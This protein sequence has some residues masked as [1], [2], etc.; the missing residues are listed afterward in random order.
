MADI[1]WYVLYCGCL[2]GPQKKLTIVD[3]CGTALTYYCILH[4]G[5]SGC[6]KEPPLYELVR[7]TG[8]EVK[9]GSESA[10]I[11]EDH[12]AV[13]ELIGSYADHDEGSK[14]TEDG[15]NIEEENET[16]EEEKD[17]GAPY[18]SEED[19]HKGLETVHI[20][21]LSHENSHIGVNDS[22]V[23]HETVGSSLQSGSDW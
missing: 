23:Q 2:W 9:D 22:L 12:D 6:T 1:L 3:M 5:Y 17:G 4:P 8:K 11:P 13:Q 18:V 16:E 10:S 21:D 7:K 15:E 19:H 14:Q 20:P